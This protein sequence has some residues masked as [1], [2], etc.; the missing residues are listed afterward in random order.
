MDDTG[1]DTGIRCENS[2]ERHGEDQ[3]S[4]VETVRSHTAISSED[5][6]LRST[7]S[8]SDLDFFPFSH[9]PILP[10]WLGMV[11]S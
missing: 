7:V 8:P 1:P 9:F 4:G 11:K 3:D 6:T 5:R 2:N 10:S